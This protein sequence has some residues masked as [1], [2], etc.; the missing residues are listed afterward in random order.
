PVVTITV[1]QVDHQDA[2]GPYPYP[3][4]YEA[5]VT[6]GVS[7]DIS[8][9]YD[10]LP[11]QRG[12][13]PPTNAEIGGV[14][15][16]M[17]SVGDAGMMKYMNANSYRII[18]DNRCYAVE[19]VE[20]GS[21]YRDENTQPGLS[22]S[23]LN[24]YFDD[25]GVI[26]RSFRFTDPSTGAGASSE[27]VPPDAAK[28]TFALGSTRILQPGVLDV[29]ATDR[30]I[31]SAASGQ[32][33]VLSTAG[34]AGNNPDLIVTSLPDGKELLSGSP[35]TTDWSTV[36]SK[37]QKL[38]V[39]VKNG[40]P[41]GRYTLFVT[42]PAPVNL[43]AGGGTTTRS[44]PTP[45][46][47]PVDYAVHVRAGQHL[48]AVLQSSGGDAKLVISGHVFGSDYVAVK[49]VSREVPANSLTVTAGRDQEYVVSIIPPAKE[50][51]DYKITFTAT[52]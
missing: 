49:G 45:N 24:G 37:T 22:D 26:A 13:I 31:L 6:V 12:P 50:V 46:G 35:W 19:Q 28:L 16:K 15:F 8:H 21:D 40:G 7:P 48:S 36:L 25:A 23:Q 11:S 10:G 5:S 20:N 3:R 34:E 33:V 44:G 14:A 39:Q 51:I 43:P 42:V 17:L 47:L 4:Y 29:G 18:H 30:Y 41:A 1:F 2:T 32:A 9:C 38:L 27:I 52:D